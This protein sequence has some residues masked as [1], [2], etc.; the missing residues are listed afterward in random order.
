[1]ASRLGAG[2]PR[3]YVHTQRNA[4][5]VLL[6][7]VAGAAMLASLAF[8]SVRSLPLGPRLTLAAAALA[9]I[10]AAFAFSALTIDVDD[11]RLTWHFGAGLL[12][13]TVPLGEVAAAE[14]TTTSWIEGVGVHLTTR[15][16]L[17]NVGG[18][19]AVLVTLRDGTWFLLGTDEPGA[20]VRALAVPR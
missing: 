20:L 7:G 2:A 9:M 19:G 13:K 1:M 8:P 3:R 10:G 6:F 5:V 11:D 4:G 18:R 14:A 15:G 17:Y 12:R 16:W